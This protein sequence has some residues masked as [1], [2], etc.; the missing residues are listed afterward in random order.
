MSFNDTILK[1][2]KDFEQRPPLA[3][4]DNIKELVHCAPQEVVSDATLVTDAKLAELKHHT[5]SP[6]A[7]LFQK[8][9]EVIKGIG[10]PAKVVPLNTYL[11]IA[12]VAASVLL[13]FGIWKLID[14]N[15]QP[16]GNEGEIVQHSTPS[17][18]APIVPAVEDIVIGAN[19]TTK[20]ESKKSHSFAAFKRSSIVDLPLVPD[21]FSILIDGA[22]FVVKDNDLYSTFTS[23]DYNNLPAFIAAPEPKPYTLRIDKS[24]AINLSESMVGMMQKMYRTRSSGKPTRKALRMKKKMDKWKEADQT[25][26]D[27]HVEKNPVNPIDLGEFLF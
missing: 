1:Q 23:F 14:N 18:P 27:K 4:F 15:P 17:V 3:L 12:A 13:L 20:T 7:Y 11:K 8:I 10:Q 9:M 21:T 2:L 19:T 5:I 24:T 6:P 26:F 25:Y 22:A 16:S